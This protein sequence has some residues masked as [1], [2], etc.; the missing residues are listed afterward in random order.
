MVNKKLHNWAVAHGVE[1]DPYVLR[2]LSALEDGRDLSF[3]ATLDPTELLPMVK[4]RKMAKYARWS[5]QLTLWR[6]VI[7][8][9]PLALTWHA[10]AEATSAFE[11]FL[12]RNSTTT[13]N[14]LEFW[15]NGYGVLHEFWRIGNVARLDV[16]IILLIIAMSIGSGLLHMHA[17]RVEAS[18]H[19]LLEEERIA[20]ALEIGQF[21]HAHREVTAQVVD[22][23]VADAVRALATASAALT[24]AA[25][26]VTKTQQHYA[27]VS[28][29]LSALLE[30]LSE[31]A[32]A[33][34]AQVSAVRASLAS[35]IGELAATV[36]DLQSQVND[37]VIGAGREVSESARRVNA[38]ILEL[39]RRL[40]ALL[41]V[42]R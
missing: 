8:F 16:Y 9:I 41:D 25:D 27:D 14:F 34:D 5:T 11:I 29:K 15:Q 35:T 20:L 40:S 42:E 21:L 33:T 28:P 3:W 18:E 1:R 19:Q 17:Q 24:N 26:E 7:I 32:S 22:A 36:T 2:L 39:H 38:Q 12:S 4:P 30:S 31:L 23:Q 10:I 37:G 13:A 6:N